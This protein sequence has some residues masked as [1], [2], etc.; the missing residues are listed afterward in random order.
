MHCKKGFRLSIPPRI[1][2]KVA[3]NQLSS[4]DQWQAAHG[5]ILRVVHCCGGDQ[6]VGAVAAAKWWSPN[7]LC[8]ARLRVTCNPI[9]FGAGVRSNS[10]GR[11]ARERRRQ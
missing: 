3:E 1:P 9:F 2:V 4:E 6:R 11:G 8:E 10:S 7:C 5:G